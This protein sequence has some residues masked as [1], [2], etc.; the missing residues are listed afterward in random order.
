MFG[1]LPGSVDS[2]PALPPSASTV[3]YHPQMPTHYPSSHSEQPHQG[4]SHVR[5]ISD[6]HPSWFQ[7]P[8][9]L[10]T[11]HYPNISEPPCHGYNMPPDYHGRMPSFLQPEDHTPYTPS[12]TPGSNRN[13]YGP[14]SIDPAMS[15]SS[16]GSQQLSDPIE[17]DAAQSLRH[18]R[19]TKPVV[20]V[21]QG[22]EVEL[23]APDPFDVRGVDKA[24]Q[25]VGGVDSSES[26][27]LTTY[28][29]T[30]LKSG[31]FADCILHLSH[32][33]D[34]FQDTE[35]HV[36]SLLMARSPLLADLLRHA[37]TEGN[38]QKR[39]HIKTAEKFILPDAFESALHHLYGQS[40]LGLEEF[41]STEF[42][43]FLKCLSDSRPQRLSTIE[44]RMDFAIAY[45][46]AG[47]HLQVASVE[48]RG[49][50]AM[51]SLLRW[52]T[53]EKA[54]TFAVEANASRKS[55]ADDTA[56]PY[57]TPSS[58]ISR[59]S[60]TISEISQTGKVPKDAIETLAVGQD[61]ST[62]TQV[63][64]TY[65]PIGYSLL[66]DIIE[67]I[68]NNL[69]PDFELHASACDLTGIKRLPTTAE[70][71]PLVS[72]PR[73]SL[74]QFGDWPAEG[75]QKPTLQSMMLSR[76]LLSVPFW[77][78]QEIFEQLSKDLHLQLAQSIVGERERRRHRALRSKSVPWSARMAAK[79][80]WGVVGWEESLDTASM[81]GGGSLRLTRRWTGFRRHSR[82]KASR[83]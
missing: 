36:H 82:S 31:A 1:G 60:S 12:G 33:H 5:H 39:I 66:H 53:I 6:H 7:Y 56:I 13:P 69:P 10:S 25:D 4:V 51:S 83:A 58:A 50:Q 43:E 34:K 22:T 65:G 3:S 9:Y 16:L 30:Q 2:S 32:V 67:Y 61:N 74:I 48:N 47:H 76:I 24:V 40:L 44:A 59:R 19:N 11:L 81:E 63:A 17:L 29:L 37:E 35:F 54:L 55:S 64:S 71:K 49:F 72:P 75:F 26:A 62:A 42:P 41:S 68:I 46:A 14:L 79:A 57:Q 78:L 23:R 38:G 73:L 28:L 52:E 80:E 45:A 18:G 20:Y 15:A 77:V 21:D 8:P 27:N 70:S